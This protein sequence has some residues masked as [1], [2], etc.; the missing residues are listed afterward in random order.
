MGTFKQTDPAATG[1]LQSRPSQP[2][3]LGKP[4]LHP[5]QLNR[6]RDGLLYVPASYRAEHPAPLVLMLHGA[7]GDAAGALNILRS[8][9]DPVGAIVLAVD[10]RR[11]TWDIIMGHYGPDIAFIDRALRQTFNRYAIHPNRVAVAG[12]SDGA[13]YALSLGIM[14]GD[15]F[16]HVLA[17]S[18]GFVAPIRQAGDPHIFISH[19]IQDRVLPIDRCSRKLVPQLKAADYRVLYEE[20]EGPHTVPEAIAR[21]ALEWFVRSD[22]NPS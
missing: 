6:K 17:F 9:V 22:L 5:L 13:S 4:G 18:P 14:N 1:Q 7:G 11:Q 20:F 21:A 12:F 2:A 3:T 15:L 19:G 8:L 10:S 16:T